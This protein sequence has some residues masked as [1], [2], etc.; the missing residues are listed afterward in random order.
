[1]VAAIKAAQ[2]GLKTALI[3]KGSLGG[4]CL[5]VGC[6]PT[7]A[8]LASAAAY[9]SAKAARDF[10]VTVEGVAFDF[11][12]IMARKARIVKQLRGGV[13]YLM[14]KNAVT[15]L[16]GAGT[17]TGA[18]SLGVAGEAERDITA[19]AIILASGSVPARPPIPGIAGANVVTSDEI[20]FW[21]AVPPTLAVIGAGAIGLEFAYFFNALGS[22]VTVLEALPQVLPAEDA[23]LAAELATSLTRQG[24]AVQTGA[25]VLEIGDADGKKSVRFQPAGAEEAQRVSAD[26][27]LVATGRWPY[28]HGC[29]YE[30]QGIPIAHRAVTVDAY[31]HTG[32]AQIYAIGDL[33]GGMLL[34]HK[35]SAEAAVAVDNITGARR[36]MHYHAIPTALYCC[37][38]V[39]SVGLS[40][41]AAAEQG[42]EVATGSF[43]FRP[44]GKA[45]AIGER[46]GFVKVVSRKT[47]GVMLGVQAIG[48]HV[49]DMIAAATMAVQ[50]GL[51]AEQY[52]RTIH[53]H[54]TLS[55]CFHEAI[56]AALG[57][58]VHM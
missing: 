37:P 50:H 3:E 11:A 41:A 15:V 58:P 47:D 17:L 23:Q 33:I 10:G 54:P 24:I 36:A 26:V 8:L 30:A 1:Y 48:P 22:T 34:A 43:P 21:D 13:E 46:E 55:E 16:A 57:H 56:E 35:A 52:A 27:V 9:T 6:I 28:T 19:G 39:A 18:H 4:T 53:P 45:L 49:T 51:T 2:R 12:K 31:L 29:G 7:K 42:I 38:E 40:E 5:N 32:V 25:T 20:L 14:K 44:L